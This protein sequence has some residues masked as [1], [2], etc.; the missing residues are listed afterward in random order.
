MAKTSI[1][2]AEAVW[3]PISGCTKVSLGCKNCYAE[4]MA[5]RL[6]AMGVRGYYEHE[7]VN[8]NGHWTGNI[9]QIQEAMELPLSWKNPRRIFV[10]SMS[11]L[12]HENVPFETITEIFSVMQKASRHTFLVLTKR[13]QRMYD[14]AT[15][16]Y[17]GNPALPNIWM[18]VSVEDQQRAN[19]RIPWLLDTPAAVR[20]VS[21]EPLLGEVKLYN[22][23]YGNQGW[24]MNALEGIHWN[25]LDYQ[26]G[27]AKLN[28][29]ICGGESGPGAR[30]MQLDWA[31]SLRDQCQEAGVPFLF[32]Q[33]GAWQP[34]YVDDPRGPLYER[35]GKKKAGRLLDGRLWDEYPR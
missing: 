5:K 25:Y 23:P 14:W 30:P 16:F 34:Q 31:R 9:V 3:N 27:C 32:K 12:F 15:S 22:I 26:H 1:E 13:A 21:C 18:G 7:I 10:N 35:V 28:W 6:A 24:K 29:V 8:S 11:D 20:F 2:W 19:E 4:R 33:W 17:L